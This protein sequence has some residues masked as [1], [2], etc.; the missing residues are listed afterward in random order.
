M[1]D[2]SLYDLKDKY[3]SEISGGELQKVFIG[4][5]LFQD[6]YVVL[7]DEFNNNLDLGAQIYLLDNINSLF[8]DKII[9]SVFHDLNLVRRLNSNIMVLNKGTI[10]THGNIES[11]FKRDILEDIYGVDVERFMIESFYNWIKN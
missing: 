3:I 6:P 4:R 2:L 7:L 1:K 11:V 10:Y 9:I 8:K 5:L